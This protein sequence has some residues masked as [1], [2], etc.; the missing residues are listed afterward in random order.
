MGPMQIPMLI[1][2]QQA[3][4]HDNETSQFISH[5]NSLSEWSPKLM[6]SAKSSKSVRVVGCQ[7]I[8]LATARIICRFCFSR[9]LVR[10]FT[11]II[12]PF[13]IANHASHGTDVGILKSRCSVYME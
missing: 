6:S 12:G 1:N 8:F 11:F 3:P 5:P 2:L 13:S 7:C 9:S 10:G 4:H